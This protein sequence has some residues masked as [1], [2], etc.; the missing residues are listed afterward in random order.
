MAACSKQWSG[1]ATHS[2]AKKKNR[3]EYFPI[4]YLLNVNVSWIGKLEALQKNGKLLY[5]KQKGPFC[6]WYER[7]ILWY[8][9]LR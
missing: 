7:S 1:D 4:F 2:G 9:V 8:Y 6:F 5:V 3:P